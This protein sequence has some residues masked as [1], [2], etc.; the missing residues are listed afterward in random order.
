MENKT[1]N[2]SGGLLGGVILGFGV[3][4]IIDILG[5]WFGFSQFLFGWSHTF[6]IASPLIF[7]V[8]GGII[9]EIIKRR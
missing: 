6:A 1:K 7:A 5:Y 3:W 4:F 2:K 9:G 8:V